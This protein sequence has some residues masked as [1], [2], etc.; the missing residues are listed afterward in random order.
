MRSTTIV[1]IT[2]LLAGCGPMVPIHTIDSA[3]IETVL[4]ANEMPIVSEEEATSMQVIGEVVGYSCQNKTGQPKATEAGAI[5][6]AKIVAVQKGGS[7]ITNVE[8]KTGVGNCW[9]SWRC[10]ATALK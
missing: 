5:D 9:N 6:Q 1:A 4:A 2:F 7:A 10:S 3:G 8:C